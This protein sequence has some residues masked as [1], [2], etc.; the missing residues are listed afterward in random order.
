MKDL[1]QELEEAERNL[2]LGRADAA[3]GEIEAL[4]SHLVAGFARDGR[5]RRSGSILERA[6]VSVRNNVVAALCDIHKYD[7]GLWRHLYKSVRTGALCR[8]QSDDPILW[9]S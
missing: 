9:E 3:M 2:D 5:P 6:R 4:R 1:E 7:D 8:Y